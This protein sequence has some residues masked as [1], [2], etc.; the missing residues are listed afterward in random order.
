[1]QWDRLTLAAFGGIAALVIGGTMLYEDATGSF[2]PVIGM[3]AGVAAMAFAS[4]E[5]LKL[6]VEVLEKRLSQSRR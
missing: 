2:V 4:L 1:M 3:V 5:R 6:R